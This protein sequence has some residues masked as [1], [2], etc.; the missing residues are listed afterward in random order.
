MQVAGKRQPLPAPQALVAEVEG[1]GIAS[2]A[3]LF[4]DWGYERRDQ[5]TFPN[6]KLQVGRWCSMPAWRWPAAAIFLHSRHVPVPC[7][8][9]W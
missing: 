5:L 9:H 8:S 6:K 1:L 7:S 3:S 2:A 4:T